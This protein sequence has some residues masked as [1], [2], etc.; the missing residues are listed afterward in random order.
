MKNLH[1]CNFMAYVKVQTV[2]GFINIFVLFIY[3][4]FKWFVDCL[5][6][7]TYS[8][9]LSL[10]AWILEFKKEIIQEFKIQWVAA[11]FGNSNFFVKNIDWWIDDSDA[12]F[13]LK[14]LG[15][16]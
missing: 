11:T 8:L 14:T 7:M 6:L 13:K 1:L 15:F 3:L 4:F 2:H 12:S 5:P 9:K 10:E 16:T